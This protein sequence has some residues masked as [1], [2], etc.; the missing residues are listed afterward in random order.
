MTLHLHG[1]KPCGRNTR[2]VIKMSQMA[3]ESNTHKYE[4]RAEMMRATGDAAGRGPK[5]YTRRN[6]ILRR[7]VC[8]LP[9]MGSVGENKLFRPTNKLSPL[10][11]FALL[12]ALLCL[13]S[14]RNRPSQGKAESGVTG[15]RARMTR[16]YG[17]SATF[18]M[19]NGF[20]VGAARE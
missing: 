14:F 8:V 10:F 19:P 2:R 13:L 15:P 18:L 20:A 12:S 5:C 3:P 11:S 6:A 7:C 4:E 17:H 1:R 16:V 9:C